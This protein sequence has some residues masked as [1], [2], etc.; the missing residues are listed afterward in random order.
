M[1]ITHPTPLGTL[2]LE[3]SGTGLTSCAFAGPLRGAEVDPGCPAG[4]ADPA[5][6]RWLELAR[7]ELDAYFAGGPTAFTVPVDLGGLSEAHRRV[8]H[9]LGPIGYGR[10]VTYGAMAA[11]LGLDAGGARSVG[12]AMARNP[13][14]I[15]IPCH[16]VVGADGSLTGYAGGPERKRALLDLEARDTVGAQLTLTG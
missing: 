4:T 8:L 16:R 11:A 12:G 14:L 15:V 10:T 13:V 2:V 5:G 6:R 3:A 1:P 9:G 7:R